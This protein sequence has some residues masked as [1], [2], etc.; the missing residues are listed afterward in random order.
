M[1]GVLTPEK[2]VTVRLMN[3]NQPAVGELT[4][5]LEP[6]R[7]A[8]DGAQAAPAEKELAPG[9]YLMIREKGDVQVIPID[10]EITHIGRGFHCEVHLDDQSVSRRH[11]ILMRRMNVTRILDDRSSNGTFVNGRRISAQQLDDG[12]V[13]V[14]GRLILE[15]RQISA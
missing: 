5:R 4:E 8:R 9:G 6:L 13:I 11:A 7:H 2:S 15:Y 3:T 12:D 14:L 10:R 1:R